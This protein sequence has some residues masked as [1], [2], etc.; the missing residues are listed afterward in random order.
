MEV[1]EA[2]EVSRIILGRVWGI[3]TRTFIYLQ[4]CQQFAILVW[5][6]GVA[7]QVDMVIQSYLRENEMDYCKCFKKCLSAGWHCGTSFVWYKFDCKVNAR[8]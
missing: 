8:S 1:S 3:T 7:V 2:V 6:I 4:N 5:E